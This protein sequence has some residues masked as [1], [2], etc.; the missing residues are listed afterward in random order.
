MSDTAVASRY[1][2]ALYELAKEA[3]REQQVLKDLVEVKVALDSDP[4]CLGV[5]FHPRRS[6]SEKEQALEPV[7]AGKDLL[8]GNTLRL[9][10]RKRREILLHHF[11][12]VYLDVHEKREGI[13][14]VVVET[15]APVDAATKDSITKRL[16]EESGKEV[17]TDF[18]VAKGIL[19]GMRFIIGSTVLDGSLKGRLERMRTQ[20]K[21]VS[22]S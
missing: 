19:G 5:L 17:R 11:F 2:E 9:I 6:V 3:G 22:L 18:R 4:R 14:R 15:A 16:A 12:G 1:A 8:V 10:V 21:A 13:L 7:L 20:L